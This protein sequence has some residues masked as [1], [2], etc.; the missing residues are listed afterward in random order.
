MSALIPKPFNLA[1]LRLALFSFI[2]CGNCAW[3][4][5]A[6]MVVADAARL[7]Y[8]RTWQ[9]DDGLPR[10]TIT[11]ITQTPDGYLW[12][13]T[14]QGVIRF[15]GVAFTPIEANDSKSFVR[16]RTL[17]LFADRLGR[18][19]IGT[20][21]A[22]IVRYDR[23]NFTVID[24][25]NGLPHPTITAL[26]EDCRGTVWLACQNGS[27]AW[28]DAEDMVHPV[29]PVTGKSVSEAI[30]LVRDARGRLWFAQHDTYGQLVEGVAT[31]VNHIADAEVML[32]P[33]RDGG[34]WITTGTELQKRPPPDSSNG[35]ESTPL[36]IKS[37]QVRC[38]LEDHLGNLWIG[39][40]GQGL[41]RY[42]N[43]KFTR[44][45]ESAHRILSL[46]EDAEASL[47]VGTQGGGLTRLRPKMFYTTEVREGPPNSTLLSVCEDAHGNMWLSSQGLA[48][49]KLAAD[50]RTTRFTAFTNIGTT[51]VL[52]DTAGGVW[53]GTAH[54]GLFSIQDGHESP[55]TD[56]TRLGDRQI[57][58]LHLDAKG[59]LWIGCHPD[60]LAKL[61]DGKTTL[62]FK[63]FDEGAP[64]QAIWAI[65]DDPGGRLWLGTINGELWGYNGS[66]FSC[67]RQADGLPGA[68]V[69]ALLAATNGDL[70]IGTLGGGLGRLRHGHFVF[71]DT[72]NGLADNVI[73]SIV[74]DGLGY[75]W[76][77]TEQGICR[78]KRQDLE[79]FAD[80]K[81]DHLDCIR[82]GKDEGLQSVECI[83]GYQPAVWH[84]SDGKIWFATSKGSVAVDPA[85][86]PTNPVPPPLVL[87][88]IQI[89]DAPLT[90]RANI[91]I[92]YGYR[93]L[94]FQYSAPSFS[95]P[96]RIR[97][98]HQ[99][100]GL[101]PDWVDAGSTRTVA[102]PRL[103]PGSY[104]FQFTAGNSSGVW[105]EKPVSVAFQ[106]TPA[107]WQTAWFRVLALFA[108]ASLV[109]SGVRYRYKQK[110]RR[111]LRALEHA[112]A[113]EQERMRIARDI[114]DDLGARLTQ[115]ALLSEMSAGE[116]G[117][118][119][120]AG[121][122]LEKIAAGSRQAIRSLEEIV[123]AVNPR[124]DSL[125]DFLD[126]LS[127][128]ANEFFRGTEIRCRQDLPMIIP[129]IPLSAEVR[130]HLFLACK[131][132]LNNIHKHAQ[133]SEVW[134]RMNLSGS[135]LKLTIEDNG[136]GFQAPARTAAGNGLLNLQSRLAAIGGQC[137]VDSQAGRGTCVCFVVKLPDDFQ[138]KIAPTSPPPA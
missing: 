101:D 27:L 137:Q 113:V 118:G 48:L 18:L 38:L 8:A 132:T 43:H 105:N 84:A 127:H 32:C 73:C 63:Y 54:H 26:C 119:T 22:G 75:F 86:L 51:C 116:L 35:M 46:Y 85:A 49:T 37:Y 9:T 131:E 34:L 19:W 61:A 126:F 99:L 16:A 79:D 106:V 15:D 93:N 68:A 56:F 121:E 112:H 71:A 76:L 50:G 124:K 70:W 10:N 25:R 91:T 59:Q 39:T 109:A 96:E 5:P 66:H 60:G 80:R 7:F 11:A 13:G 115:M 33:S 77:G 17:V 128:Y 107:Y 52:P 133:A 120:P 67:Y 3:A 42:A 28:V 36:P 30:Q 55:V 23:E 40:L 31:N 95:S 114:H 129:E 65:A 104:V 44:E 29:A 58:A 100:V 57:R 64:K 134:L 45:L 78:V 12:L 92:A 130:H 24:S 125:S 87:E 90:N 103:A 53:V 41:V 136:R 72:R 135:E 20:G 74:G 6:E 98:R 81:R 1:L 117:Q 21:T 138:E 2:I 82:Y 102:Y 94:E 122:R 111:K 62:P 47:W 14:L 110:M 4:S 88:K 123:W 108:F 97:F 83:E 69:G 89:D